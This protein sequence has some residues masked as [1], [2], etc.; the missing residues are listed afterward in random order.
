MCRPRRHGD[1]RVRNTS[2]GDDPARCAGR[3]AG[4]H[5]RHPG[6]VNQPF[7]AFFSARFSSFDFAGFFL[8]SFFRSMPLPMSLTPV[9]I[10]RRRELKSVAAIRP[11][12]ADVMPRPV[13]QVKD[14]SPA[15]LAPAFD[16]MQFPRL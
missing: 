16:V 2:Q 7:L 9:V 11:E 4:P 14:A 1:R 12:Q 10:G 13:V 8:V 5:D 3:V 15:S 6:F